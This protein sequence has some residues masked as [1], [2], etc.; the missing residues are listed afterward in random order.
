MNEIETV[1]ETVEDVETSTE[2]TLGQTILSAAITGV[3]TTAACM[4][5]G[6]VISAGA[7]AIEKIKIK[8]AQKKAAT[9]ED[10][11]EDVEIVTN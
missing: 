4:A 7:K 1:E 5:T 3:V 11:S 8:R 6:M 10:N 9:V 2:P